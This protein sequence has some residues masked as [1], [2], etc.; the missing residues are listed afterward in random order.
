MLNKPRPYRLAII[1]GL[2][3]L[4][5]LVLAGGALGAPKE[6]IIDFDSSIQIFADG[7]LI[8]TETI[9]VV[10]AGDMIRHGIYRDFPTRYKDRQGREI[11]VGFSL[12][13]V[14]RDGMAE[15]YH[16]KSLS[17]G[18]RIYVGKRDAFISPGLH[19]FTLTYRTDR[20]LGFFD[21]HD[22][23]YWNVTGNGWSFQIDQARA[24]VILPARIEP[25]KSTAYT[26]PQGSREQAFE[27]S[28]SESGNIVFKTT[29]TLK[30]REGLTIVVAWPKGF[31]SEPSTADNLSY[32]AK[33]NAGF[34]IAVTAF[35]VLFAYYLLTWMKVGRDPQKGAIIPRFEPPQG[36]SPAA[37]RH[38]Y[39][40]RFDQK[41]FT[42]TVVGLAVKGVLTITQE[43]SKAYTLEKVA[44]ADTAD[45]S[46]GEKRVY[47]QLFKSR[48]RLQLGS[49]HIGE[50]KKAVGALNKSLKTDFSKAYFAD[51]TNRLLPGIGIVVIALIAMVLTAR[52]T[53][54][55]AGLGL[56][57]SMWTLACTFLGYQVWQR[58]RQP[59]NN[60]SKRIGRIVL[61]LFSLPFFGA[62]L[63]GLWAFAQKVSPR[64][65]LFFIGMLLLTILFY[66]LLKAPTIRGRQ[67]MDKI[68]GF[69][70]YLRVAES[71]RLKILNPPDRTPELFEKLLPY[72]IALD[73]EQQWSQQ[74]ED[75]L[76]QANDGKGY[77]AHW[78]TGP[79][80][81]EDF[82]GVASDLGEGLSSAVASSATAPGSSSGFGG[83]GGAGGGGGG[84]GGGGW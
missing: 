3:A 58:W 63:F 65:T 84:G 7:H 82:H 61:T 28:Y 22:E 73:A 59:A 19:T 30:P 20:Q 75:V 53:A 77:R 24:E 29:R 52:D 5:T 9:E 27:R 35:V 72:A 45:L 38:I 25:L 81:G 47:E 2:M 62:Q 78:Y 83:G 17:N 46:K 42:A 21:Q 18:I 34:L 54:S 8:V 67:V 41:S 11:E 32:S 44:D 14:T 55:A 70:Q 71:E 15:A 64:A 40:R 31:V 10:S 43:D 4:W 12:L 60:R 57:L 50:V 69:R 51:N 56:W 26:G 36:F 49:G 74:F 48:S 79:L 13:N 76:R 23:L 68:E 33:R 66:H 37:V 1:I 16:T 39:K 6:R 80:A